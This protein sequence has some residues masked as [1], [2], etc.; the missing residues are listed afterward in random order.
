[1]LTQLE[2]ELMAVFVRNRV[3]VNRHIAVLLM[4]LADKLESL[5]PQKEYRHADHIDQKGTHKD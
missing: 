5:Q 4:G 3:L 1:M 2:L